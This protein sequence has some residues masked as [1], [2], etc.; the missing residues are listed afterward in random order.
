MFKRFIALALSA[1]MLLS[2]GFTVNAEE[3]ASDAAVVAAEENKLYCLTNNNWT[4]ADLERYEKEA[5]FVPENYET[6]ATYYYETDCDIMGNQHDPECKSQVSGNLTKH[7]IG[8]MIWGGWRGEMQYAN[9]YFNIVVDLGD[10]YWVSMAD[11]WD[12]VLRTGSGVD[13]LTVSVGLDL[14][15]MM[16]MPAVQ[17]PR[18]TEEQ[19]ASASNYYPNR[20]SVE[21]AAVNAR[22]VKFS[23]R[24]MGYQQNPSELAVFGYL[25]KPTTSGGE[26]L[27]ELVEGELE[28]LAS[29]QD[30]EFNEYGA[31]VIDLGEVKR[32]SEIDV[33][34]YTSPV[35]GLKEY[36]VW[37][38][39]DGYSYA[40]YTKSYPV[41]RA[42][43]T[44]ST[45]V[46]DLAQ[47]PY[48]RFVKIV[49]KKHDT[50]Q[51]YKIRKI[52]VLGSAGKAQER[53]DADA[54]YSYW[55]KH[56]YQTNSDIIVQDPDLSVLM[57]GNTENYIT[58]NDKWATVVIDLGK[59]Y[60]IG[61]VDI[62][63]LANAGHF[64]E[65]AEIRYSLDNKKWFTY[66][67]YVNTND[68]TG[69]IV[70]SSFCGQPGR[71]A[72]YL[73]VIAQSTDHAISISE[74]EVN[75]YDV[76][77]PRVAT[78]PQVPLRIE[79]K[80][81]LLA[82]F[83][84][85]TYN[86]DNSS[87]YSIYVEKYPFTDVSLLTP[88]ATYERF[89]K[90]FQDKYT[91]YQPL[92]PETEYYFAV[93]AYND[94]GQENT[95]V[96]PVK[97]VTDQ[98]LGDEVG[99][100][101]NITHHP[102]MVKNPFGSQHQTQVADIVRLYDELG[103]SNKTSGWVTSGSDKFAAIGVGITHQSFNAGAAAVL[104]G[105]WFYTA[106]N[107]SDLAARPVDQYIAE[108]KTLYNQ[109]KAA[110]P[111]T[112]MGFAR[113]GGVDDKCIN[114]LDR[115]YA[116]DAQGVIEYSDA[117]DVHLY[118]K[119]GY[120]Q[121]PGLPTAC[122]E[123]MSWMVARLR[124]IMDKYGDY[125]KPIT[126]TEGGYM[127]TTKAGYAAM[128]NHE[129]VAQYVPRLYMLAIS[130]GVREWWYYA[131]QDEGV[132]RQDTEQCWGLVDYFGV[133]KAQYYS[134]YNTYYNLRYTDYLGAVAGLSNPY[135]G[136]NFYDET[137]GKI[138]SSA[139]AAD[140]KE[141]T[142]TFETL[143]GEDELIEVVTYDGGFQKIQTKNGE[144]AVL[145]GAGPVYI[146]SKEGIKA[147]STARAFDLVEANLAASK[148]QSVT[149]NISRGTLGQ[150]AS[151]YIAA[152]Q[153]PGGW[154]LVGDTSFNATQATIPVTVQVPGTATEGEQK[155]VFKAVMD[156]ARVE[157]IEA[158]ID[159]KPYMS[160]EFVPTVKTF[161]DWNT[162]RI[163]AN[164]TNTSTIPLEGKIS[165]LST[166]NI[167]ISTV[168]AQY[169]GL[170]QPGETATVYFDVSERVAINSDGVGTFAV[171][172]N[173][174]T[175]MIDRVLT[176]TACVNDGIKPVIDGMITGDEYANCDVVHVEQADDKGDCA[177]DLYR[178]WDDTHFYMLVDVTDNIF[179]N[180]Y[181][182]S[183]IWGA[184]GL[185][186]CIDF[187]R[188]EGVGAQSSDEYFELGLAAEQNTLKPL[189]WAWFTDLI[190][191]TNK[192]MTGYES[193]IT[194]D[195]TNK[196]TIYEIA[197]PWAYLMNQG[198]IADHKMCGFSL[199]VNDGD[200]DGGH[201]RTMIA[202]RN[203]I[204][205][206]KNP[207]VFEDMVF[208]KK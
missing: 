46:T 4:E 134:Y 90:A 182:G 199:L 126:C 138:I 72:R 142:L 152:A 54:T 165:C 49:A 121:I 188:K 84:W 125:D 108:N 151:G 111:R 65:G 58:T 200:N 94:F 166:T 68:K 45:I 128:L 43:M 35:N 189:T 98:V 71:N 191:K 197:I 104:R 146:Y 52:K 202:Y 77:Q 95:K 136:F 194:R 89:D 160:I 185:Q 195:E 145:I 149:F 198:T 163:A 1:S 63:S 55:Q 107:E 67:Y 26:V 56:P 25:E 175:N 14:E 91:T 102:T 5:G 50:K 88:K 82:Y 150:N 183:E 186:F 29:A 130:E 118:P 85:S 99:E 42:N 192:E 153:L 203:G 17:L 119:S 48:A 127:S 172:V 139:W 81:F 28:V 34:E 112:V 30:P 22:Y 75:G 36:E 115:C 114:W 173:G 83:D 193:V 96:T 92:E 80:N 144:G 86:N 124:R 132:D 23:T 135:Y 140:G 103:S 174:E 78:P 187:A 162:W 147:T 31:Y 171:E 207:Q 196:H 38:S 41:S 66:T 137:K 178:K 155:I 105:A 123:L 69:G 10:N 19:L 109:I 51:G 154:S 113:M 184:D 37:L 110:D 100:I 176:F 143:S 2:L 24:R 21:F 93:T 57:D 3:V 64:M 122:P 179:Y 159:V 157:N 170:L 18:A 205:N 76:T 190:I 12:I 101:F 13:T 79:M 120:D 73:K 74:I 53:I 8:Y 27:E 129:Q 164:C 97:V 106:G 39:D 133:P 181:T 167:K 117:L 32:V 116:Y 204:G 169:T 59:P 201:A 180:P 16:T 62:Y 177:F 206:G 156:D 158:S 6:K 168:A 33:T 11:I 208:I 44:E 7:E 40:Q 131:F 61:N 60:Q 148:G 87:K 161:G 47:D 70:K 15:N 9:D 20:G 141:K